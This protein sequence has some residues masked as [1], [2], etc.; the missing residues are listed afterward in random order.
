MNKINKINKNIY[1][2]KIINWYRQQKLIYVLEKYRNCFNNY[3][4]NLL[5]YFDFKTGLWDYIGL[6]SDIIIINQIENN[7]DID[8]VSDNN[9]DNY[10][11]TFDSDK[12][13]INL[14]SSEDD[15]SKD[16]YIENIME[17]MKKNQTFFQYIISFFY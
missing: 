4:L 10:Y 12:D 11:N 3:Q 8:S 16:N 15:F 5:D 1:A 14:Y 13:F 17:E 6:L 9:D 7:S 2:S